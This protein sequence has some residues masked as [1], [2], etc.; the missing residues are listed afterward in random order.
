MRKLWMQY[1][2]VQVIGLDECQFGGL[3]TVDEIKQQLAGRTPAAIVA[4]VGGGG[5]LMGVLRGL[6]RNGWGDAVPAVPCE[7]EG[8]DCLGGP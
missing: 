3:F 7:T 6:D 5:L 8:A 2:D 4:S 1:C